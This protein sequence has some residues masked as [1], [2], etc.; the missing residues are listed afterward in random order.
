[1]T[2]EDFLAWREQPMTQW[3]MKAFQ[4]TANLIE[5]EWKEGSWT[6]GVADQSALDTLKAKHGAYSSV[7]ETDFSDIQARQNDD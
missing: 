2:E 4:N 5:A 1:M 3:F 7:Y 6:T